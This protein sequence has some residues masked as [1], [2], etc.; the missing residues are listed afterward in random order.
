MSKSKDLCERLSESVEYKTIEKTESFL[1]LKNTIENYMLDSLSNMLP[2]K[3]NSELTVENKIKAYLGYASVAET[4]KFLN[5]LDRNISRYLPEL[6]QTYKIS[7]YLK[8]SQ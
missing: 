8:K 6:Y 7:D 1:N 5:S 2:L 4:K 3:V